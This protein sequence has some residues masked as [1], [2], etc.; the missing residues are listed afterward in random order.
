MN[1]VILIG[2]LGADPEVRS[3]PNGDHV[4]NLRLATSE[5]WRDKASGETKEATEWHRVVMFG[6]SAEVAGQYL[7]KG[8]QLMVEGKIKTR[9]WQ[10]QDGKDRYSTEIHAERFEML[11]SEGRKNDSNS[12]TTEHHGGD[13]GD[14]DVPF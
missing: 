9:K 10:G 14:G 5:K 8:S 7:K 11:G 3:M 6:R 13:F 2:H 12:S 4:A 1:K